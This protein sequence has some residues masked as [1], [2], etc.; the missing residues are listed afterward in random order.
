MKKRYL[1][2]IM[3]FPLMGILLFL[4][5]NTSVFAEVKI[6]GKVDPLLSGTY[7]SLYAPAKAKIITQDSSLIE[8]ALP[9]E[10]LKEVISVNWTNGEPMVGAFIKVEGSI[11]EL[12]S[13]GVKVHSKIDNIVTADVP[14]VK[15]PEIVA[16]SNVLRIEAAK[17]VELDL[18]VATPMVN[19]PLARNSFGLTGKG[20]IIGMIDSGL[21]LA[22]EDFKDD[23]GKTRVL[24]LWDQLDNVGPHPP[25]YDYGTGWTKND[26]DQGICR[27]KATNGHGT[28][29]SGIATGSGK[30]TGNG[31]PQY[32]YIGVAPEADL[33]VVNT[34]LSNNSKVTDAV[35]YVGNKAKELGKPW[36]ANLSMGAFYGPR[37][38]TSPFEQTIYGIT[39]QDLGKGKVIVVSA[40]N[41]GYDPN[42]P[43]VI[44]NNEEHRN[45]KNH[46]RKQGNGSITMEVDATSLWDNEIV[47]NEIWYPFSQSFQVTITSP[48]GRTYGPFGPGE[49]T[50]DP[51]YG[52]IYFTDTDGIVLCHNE[53]FDYSWPEPFPFSP[54]NQIIIA[55]A[56]VYYQ[57]TLYS[58]A[59]G[60]WTITMS[61]GSDWWDSY[62]LYSMSTTGIVRFNDAS[63]ENSRKITE[64]GN[65]NNIITVGSFNS[66]NSWVDVNNHT[67]PEFNNLFVSSGY[68]VEEV[69]FF[70]S[71]GPTRDGRDKPEIYAPGAWI[72]SSLS[73]QDSIWVYLLRQYQEKDGVH[74]NRMGT[75]ASAPFVTG[76]VALLL[77]QDPDYSIGDIKDILYWTSTSE[78]FLDIY[79]AVA[80]YATGDVNGDGIISVSDIVF[81]INYLFKGGTA[82]YPLWK[83]DANGDCQVSLSD[84][85][86][87]ISFLFKGGDPPKKG[88]A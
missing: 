22:N 59:S 14:L 80:L 27:Q 45:N 85:V 43:E 28:Y 31:I 41:E 53:H 68:P 20:V 56:D 19:A 76:A 75:S 15:L 12:Q 49:G 21:D 46:A 34:D 82:P 9:F 29:T 30:S 50:G 37:D 1:K 57:G 66:K 54:D 40:G 18:N 62:V 24:Y 69:S 11:D 32:T 48:R 6:T 17:P 2:N 52:W 78:D 73:K 36:V 60:N 7:N 3:N 77:Q 88:C 16:L 47:W 5:L 35:L 39:N 4:C 63:Q 33:I 42:N 74:I 64:P 26:I 81:L 38:G 67:Q 10:K 79:E 65:A 71:P 70:S 8:V 13:L 72:A 87:L 55:L 61:N 25:G 84:V 58:L 83:A 23:E 86:Y 44:Q 51:G